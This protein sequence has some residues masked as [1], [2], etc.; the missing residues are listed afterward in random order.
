MNLD[1]TNWHPVPIRSVDAATP[2]TLAIT[3]AGLL[4][5]A[6]FVPDSM[7]DAAGFERWHLDKGKKP[8][9]SLHWRVALDKAAPD[10]AGGPVE[11]LATTYQAGSGH[12]PAALAKGA[13]ALR[14]GTVDYAEAIKRECETGRAWPNSYVAGAVIDPNPINVIACIVRDGLGALDSGGFESWA[15]DLGFD[16]D[17]RKA[18]AIYRQCL[19]TGLKLRLHLG[20]ARL[21]ALGAALAEE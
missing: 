19:D 21:S 11:V 10:A 1:P 16:P 4:I 6:A 5:R 15:S 7:A 9:P 3:A 20:D 2:A 17:S 14:P 18:E 12:C 8:G 13:R